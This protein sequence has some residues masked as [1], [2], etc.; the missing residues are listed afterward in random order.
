MLII[1]TARRAAVQEKTMNRSLRIILI[2][3]ALML[4]GGLLGVLLAG[5]VPVSWSQQS[6]SAPI[7]P[8]QVLVSYRYWG[9][10]VGSLVGLLAAAIF[11]F[12]RARGKKDTAY[13]TL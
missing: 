7:P 2:T 4:A 1:R 8:E 3:F 5:L 6:D 10:L 12:V 13:Q 11:F 9:V